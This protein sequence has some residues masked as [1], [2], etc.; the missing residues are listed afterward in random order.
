M[1]NKNETYKENEKKRSERNMVNWY[2]PKVSLLEE[3]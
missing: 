3:L 2:I 1:D